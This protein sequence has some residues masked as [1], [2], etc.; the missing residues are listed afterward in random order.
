MGGTYY[1]VINTCK[2]TV[3]ALAMELGKTDVQLVNIDIPNERCG[4]RGWAAPHLKI[5]FT[6]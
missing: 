2:K 4:Q 5:I 6:T 1:F 3:M